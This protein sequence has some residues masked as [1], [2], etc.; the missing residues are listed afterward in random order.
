[1]SLTN[2]SAGSGARGLYIYDTSRYIPRGGS[3]NAWKEKELDVEFH[4][5]LDIALV[6]KSQSKSKQVRVPSSKLTP[7]A[8]LRMHCHAGATFSPLAV[9]TMMELDHQADVLNVDRSS[10][11]NP[12]M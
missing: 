6:L 1:M 9:R 12:K 11:T 2:A 4:L 10:S 5:L 3:I 8:A 7:N